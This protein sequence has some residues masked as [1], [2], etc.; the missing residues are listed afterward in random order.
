MVG[1]VLGLTESMFN[2]TIGDSGGP[3][4]CEEG[5]RWILR[6]A[7]SWGHPKCES[8]STYTVYARISSYVEWINKKI[9]EGTVFSYSCGGLLNCL[10]F[11]NWL[12]DR[13][14]FT[15]F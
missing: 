9:K 2:V 6:G 13:H 1:L 7:V 12:H 10:V 3:F 11:S 8:K 15:Y 14:I 4:V 5:G